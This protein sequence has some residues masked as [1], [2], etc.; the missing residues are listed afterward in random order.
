MCAFSQSWNLIGSCYWLVDTDWL[1]DAVGGALSLSLEF[2][3]ADFFKHK[4]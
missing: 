3:G 1:V 4:F 2:V